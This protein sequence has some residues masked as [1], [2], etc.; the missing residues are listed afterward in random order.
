M[1]KDTKSL[2][3][4]RISETENFY[5]VVFFAGEWQCLKF[6]QVDIIFHY[7]VYMN[8]PTPITR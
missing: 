4:D 6:K 3:N 5:I 7:F 2:N 8:L 1:S